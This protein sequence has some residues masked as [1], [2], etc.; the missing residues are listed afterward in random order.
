MFH[1]VKVPACEKGYWYALFDTSYMAKSPIPELIYVSDLD[2]YTYKFTMVNLEGEKV[3]PNQSGKFDH[4]QL[5]SSL[6]HLD[7][8]E[9]WEFFKWYADH[10]RYDQ[11]NPEAR[12]MVGIARRFILHNR[13]SSVIDEIN[14]DHIRKSLIEK[15]WCYADPET[16]SRDLSHL[17]N[18]YVYVSKQGESYLSGRVQHSVP[19]WLESF[20]L[21]TLHYKGIDYHVR[22]KSGARDEWAIDVRFD[23]MKTDPATKFER[24]YTVKNPAFWPTLVM[25][26]L[27]DAGLI[28]FIP[29]F[30]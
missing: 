13:P 11:A 26:D 20:S 16:I 22:R 17:F 1:P 28:D 6:D 21:S 19:N 27:V 5:G 2:R 29:G 3:S 15:D 30:F 10:H 7:Q 8:H 18:P 23:Y 12:V 25:L 9:V 4:Y 24:T 14:V